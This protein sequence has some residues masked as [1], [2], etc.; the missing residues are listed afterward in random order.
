MVEPTDAEIRERLS[1]SETDLRA[2]PPNAFAEKHQLRVEADRLRETLHERLAAEL[3]AAGEQ[4]ADRA[5]RKGGHEE[6][7]E[8]MKAKVAMTGETIGNIN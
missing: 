4:W 7:P 8:A 6:D 1:R 2:L 5:A 3:S